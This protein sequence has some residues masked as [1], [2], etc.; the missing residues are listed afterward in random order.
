MLRIAFITFEYPPLIYGGLGVYSYEVTCRLAEMGCEVHVF[1]V[2]NGRY[3]VL[4]YS[5]NITIHRI[6]PVNI[7]QSL[8][9]LV[10]DELKAWGPGFK[11]FNDV[12]T[13]NISSTYTINK[14]VKEGLLFDIVSVHDWISSITGI[15]M[16]NMYPSIPLVFHIHS[17]EKGRNLGGGSPT[18]SLLELECA[19]ISNAIVTVS[20]AMRNYDLIP[21]GFP[22]EKIHVVWNG[23]DPEKYNPRRVSRKTIEEIKS[24]HYGDPLI[25]F[26]GRLVRV[27]GVDNLV[28]SM[29]YIVEKYPKARLL[30]IGVGE[31][32]EQILSEGRSIKENITVINRFL[33]EEERIAY[34]AA[35]DLAVFPSLYEPFGIVAVEAMAMEKP[36]VVGAYGCS[37][38][39]EIVVPSGSEQCGVHVNPY[40]PKDIAWGIEAILESN[41]C[42]KWMGLNGRRRVLENFTWSKTVKETLNLYK[43]LLDLK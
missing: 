19:K 15:S 30:I 1:T 22:A 13:Y 9:I 21:Q 20:N 6:I 27:K 25:L 40:D 35:C 41:D 39:R 12:L 16:K 31:L 37:G 24:K 4:E 11:Y 5:G 18:V 23:V 26:I 34:Y 42:G 3:P 2:N 29:K 7:E 32:L 43:S 8:K 38:F 14:L 28:K 33:S 17:S 10:N 36:I